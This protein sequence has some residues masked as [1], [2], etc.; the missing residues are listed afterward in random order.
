[1]QTNGLT[2]QLPLRA[3][4]SVHSDRRKQAIRKIAP[5]QW[6]SRAR[7]QSDMYCRGN[8]AREESRDDLNAMRSKPAKPQ[9]AIT[10]A[11]NPEIRDHFP[12]SAG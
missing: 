10:P 2:A 4:K 6:A 12:C 8:Y 11:Q 7:T 5:N 3:E 1:M 9:R